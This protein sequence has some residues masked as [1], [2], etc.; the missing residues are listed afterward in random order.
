MF[1][2]QHSSAAVLVFHVGTMHGGGS[3]PISVMNQSAG[4]CHCTGTAAAVVDSGSVV[5]CSRWSAAVFAID[6]LGILY[7]G[8]H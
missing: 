1:I 5:F 4:I 2:V 8:R 7:R 3:A 6:H